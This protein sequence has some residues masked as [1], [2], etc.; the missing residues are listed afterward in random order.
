MSYEWFAA[1]PPK[2][3]LEDRTNKQGHPTDLDWY[4]V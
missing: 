2:F 3:F 4:L 1:D